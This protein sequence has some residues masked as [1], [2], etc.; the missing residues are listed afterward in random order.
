MSSFKIEKYQLALR[1]L[2]RE[3]TIGSTNIRLNEISIGSTNIAW[4]IDVVSRPD[5]SQ[6][7]IR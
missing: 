1:I 7:D 5:R 2:G 4:K 3:T 6:S